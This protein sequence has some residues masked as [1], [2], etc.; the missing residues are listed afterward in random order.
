MY[1]HHLVSECRRQLKG[2]CPDP[3]D[4]RLSTRLDIYRRSKAE[5]K[6]I[7]IFTSPNFYKEDGFGKKQSKE[8]WKYLHSYKKNIGRYR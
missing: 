4:L 6:P 5:G 3:L 7:T 2:L 8:L 1:Q